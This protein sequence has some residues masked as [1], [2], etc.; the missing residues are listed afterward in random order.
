MNQ[1]LGKVE[2]PEAAAYKS[3]RKLYVVPMVRSY[4]DAPADYVEISGRYWEGVKSN[5][6]SL[7]AR[8]GK[9]T[10]VFCET[11]FVGGDEGLK[12]IEKMDSKIHEIVA[13]FCG[14]GAQ[15][16][17]LEDVELFGQFLDWSRC[18]SIG[19]ISEAANAKVSEF[20]QESVKKRKEHIEKKIAEAI[21]PEEAG[22]L[23][24][25]EG[26]AVQFPPDVEVFFIAPPAL[27]ELHRW[28]REQVR[29]ARAGESASEEK[30]SV[31]D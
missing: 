14:G 23:V 12:L 7:E 17:G 21:G 15:L 18:L 3:K 22:M 20:Y 6:A 1:E 8:A 9:T 28:Q 19:L 25:S 5:L 2:R 27:D 24:I 13:C 31:S 26:Y 16:E 29:A 4:S 30:E 11:V 10:K